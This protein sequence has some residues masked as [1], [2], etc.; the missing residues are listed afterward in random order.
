[1]PT[2]GPQ[3]GVR[4][5]SNQRRRLPLRPGAGD[6]DQL[7]HV[8]ETVRLLPESSGPQRGRREGKKVGY[9]TMQILTISIHNIP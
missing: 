6:E 7:E 9:L 8:G 3:Q 4:D 2:D 5:E 1:M